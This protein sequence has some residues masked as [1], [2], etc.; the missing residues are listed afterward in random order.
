MPNAG[1]TFVDKDGVKVMFKVLPC[2]AISKSVKT[3]MIGPGA[4]FDVNRLTAEIDMLCSYREGDLP[5]IKIHPNATVLLPRH[6]E[7]EKNSLIHIASTMQGSM[8][9]V[10][11]KMRR[12]SDSPVA[13]SMMSFMP[14][15]IRKLVCSHVEW[16]TR[17]DSIYHGIAEGAQGYSLGIDTEFYPYTTSRNCTPAAFAA[18][19]GIPMQLITN[20]VGSMRT[21]PIRVGNVIGGY[22]GDCYPDQKETSW[23]EIGQPI[24]YTTVTNRPRRIFTFSAMQLRDAIWECRPNQIFL[25]FCNYTDQVIVGNICDLVEDLGSIVKFLGFGPK[26]N[27]IL[28]TMHG[29]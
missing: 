29:H 19:M 15:D 8:E 2:A 20:I 3:V 16:R 12:T 13:K 1:H 23:D 24:E 4:V 6:T 18:A 28:E 14:K 22:S 27:D 5:T 25:N 10:I 11:E 21:Y 17:I 9:A 7:E 26:E